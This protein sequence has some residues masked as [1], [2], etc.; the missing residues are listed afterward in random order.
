MGIIRTS[1][2]S[3]NDFLEQG[4]LIEILPQY[5]IATL[6][7]YATYLQKRFYPAKLSSFVDFLQKYFQQLN[8]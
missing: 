5:R 8:N 7:I 1:K 3:A 6:S 2:L 4:T